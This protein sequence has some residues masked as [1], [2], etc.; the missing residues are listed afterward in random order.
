MITKS[1]SV[2]LPSHLI[3]DV[4]AA[5]GR[6]KLSTSEALASLL[7]KSFP[8][9]ALLAD[10]GECP[11]PWDQKLDFRIPQPIFQGLR[12]VC[13]QL[14]ISPSEYIRQLLYHYYDARTIDFVEENGRYTLAEST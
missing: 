14:Q 10:R 12:D 13:F 6:V 2:R 11:Q 8:G 3:E 9:S 4:R 1:L 5:A 7:E